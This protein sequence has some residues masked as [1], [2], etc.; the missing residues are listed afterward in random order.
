[1]YK[2]TKRA[3]RRHHYNR[4]KKRRIAGNYWGKGTDC[5]YSEWTP[6]HLG[7]AVETPCPVTCPCCG[8]PRRYHGESTLAERRSEDSFTEQVDE[9]DL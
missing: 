1:M 8:N 7:K 2:N 5:F 3:E 9:L 6:S 4:L